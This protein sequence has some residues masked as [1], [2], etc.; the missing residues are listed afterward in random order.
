MQVA[1]CLFKRVCVSHVLK[2]LLT[3]V[4]SCGDLGCQARARSCL[5]HLIRLAAEEDSAEEASKDSAT[6]TPMPAAA[7]AAPGYLYMYIH[8][9]IHTYV[10]IYINTY[11]YIY[12]NMILYM[13]VCM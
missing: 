11:T 12:I 10:Y 13:Y 6:T 5:R 1:H 9:Y 7:A 2:Y 4:H 8:I 3:C